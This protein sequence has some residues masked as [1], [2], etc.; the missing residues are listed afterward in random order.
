[1]DLSLL[2]TGLEFQDVLIA[3]AESNVHP[4]EVSIATNVTNTISLTLPFL[5]SVGMD[6]AGCALAIDLARAGGMGIVRDD[7]PVGKQ[8]EQVRRV[9]R[10]EA[11]MVTDPI[12][13]APDSALA[14][15]LDL[16]TTYKVS[17]LPVIDGQRK[18]VG[19]LTRRDVRF[20]E[21]YASPVSHFMTSENLVT[22]NRKVNHQQAK[23]ILQERK[24]EKLI[25]LDDQ[26]RCAGLVTVRDIEM[27]SQ[28]PQATRDAQKRLR[29]GACVGI[30]KD[31]LDRAM[32]LA[33]AGADVV[34]VESLQANAKDMAGTVS[35]IRQQ[36]TSE[37]QVIAGGILTPEAAQ[38]MVDNGADAIKISLPDPNHSPL[39]QVGVGIP[40]FTALIEVAQE[41]DRLNVPVLFD[42]AMGDAATF[43]K[44]MAAGASCVMLGSY[45]RKEDAHAIQPTIEELS[46]GLKQAMAYAG[47]ADLEILR[48]QAHFIKAK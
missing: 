24:V 22:V 16:M 17:A 39:R 44:V 27:L 6:E 19:I 9:K 30:A 21:D 25:V 32:A 12:T 8:V 31:G 1:M 37:V 11:E 2:R 34:I 3:P 36:R 42:G 14:E 20:V 35:R 7:M 40:A 15:A 41:C 28:N 47:A 43:A 46:N 38:S 33:D 26:G 23:Q 45:D 29:V 48:R 5:A 13:I 4:N 18:V 10:A